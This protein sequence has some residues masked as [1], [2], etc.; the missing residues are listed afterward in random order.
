MPCSEAV[1]MRMEMICRMKTLCIF[2]CHVEVPPVSQSSG[3]A[4][5][6]SNMSKLYIQY[7]FLFLSCTVDNLGTRI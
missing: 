2:F 3:N 6:K 4:R 7:E 1:R 5:V